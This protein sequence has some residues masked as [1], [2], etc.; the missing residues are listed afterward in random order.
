MYINPKPRLE[1][2]KKVF[3]KEL[4]KDSVMKEYD[5]TEATVNQWVKEYLQSEGINPIPEVISAPNDNIE[6]YKEMFKEQLINELMLKDIEIERSKKGY[7]VKGGGRT[8]EFIS[9]NSKNSK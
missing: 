6:T 9:I 4:T 8:K 1:L 7:A 2:G 3:L 5:V